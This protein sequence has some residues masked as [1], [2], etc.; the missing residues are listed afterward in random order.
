MI[1]ESGEEIFCGVG[2]SL[3]KYFL[4]THRLKLVPMSGDRNYNT[5]RNIFSE[6]HEQFVSY[7]SVGL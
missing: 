4:H 7:K 3:F 1:L 6:E 5:I 2:S